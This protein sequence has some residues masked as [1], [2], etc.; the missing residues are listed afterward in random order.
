MDAIWSTSGN[1]SDLPN[2]VSFTKRRWRLWKDDGSCFLRS[3]PSGNHISTLPCVPFALDANGPA[4]LVA[5]PGR[6][7]D[8]DVRQWNNTLF[9][10]RQS[11]AR[12]AV[13]HGRHSE[14]STYS[15]RL[16]SPNPS[17]AASRRIRS[18]VQ[19]PGKHRPHKMWLG[20]CVFCLPSCEPVARQVQL[21]EILRS[22]HPSDVRNPFLTPPIGAPLATGSDH[23]PNFH[24]MIVP[25]LDLPHQ[26]AVPR[27][28]VSPL[29]KHT[30]H[31]LQGALV[32]GTSLQCTADIG[33][34]EES[35]DDLGAIS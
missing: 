14:K 10:K 7:A 23:P 35:A 21:P 19:R 29:G 28:A 12:L 9:T 30:G 2:E 4:E 33:V 26:S 24:R 5:N 1:S 16:R 20:M 8:I 11:T 25:S 15:N 32:R 27:V 17:Q 34:Y 6:K 31:L 3:A 13:S 18:T 22:G